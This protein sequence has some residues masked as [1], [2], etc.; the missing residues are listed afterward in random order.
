MACQLAVERNQSQDNGDNKTSFNYNDVIQQNQAIQVYHYNSGV[1]AYQKDEHPASSRQGIPSTSYNIT[2]NG[3]SDNYYHNYESRNNGQMSPNMYVTAVSNH[4][5]QGYPPLTHECYVRN[6][7]MTHGL[8]HGVP[9][10]NYNQWH[11]NDYAYQPYMPQ[12]DILPASQMDSC[13]SS[14]QIDENASINQMK[15]DSSDDE[16]NSEG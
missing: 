2:G 1:S 8:N 13:T 3:I 9:N 14:F 5:Q 15:H 6:S 10:S 16:L 11:Q 4:P 7:A 12:S